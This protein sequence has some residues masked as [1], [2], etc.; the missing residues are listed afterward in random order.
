[1]NKRLRRSRERKIAGGCGGIAEYFGLDPTI[2]RLVWLFAVLFTV[3]VFWRISFV[4]S[5]FQIRK[6]ITTE[7]S[8]HLK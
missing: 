8:G 3:Q 6:C 7:G 1:M 4:G 5:S 2:I